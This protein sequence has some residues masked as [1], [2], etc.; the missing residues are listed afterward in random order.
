MTDVNNGRAGQLAIARVH[1]G[2]CGVQD[3]ERLTVAFSPN[4][5]RDRP[6]RAREAVLDGVPHRILS[7][8]RSKLSAGF[9]VAELEPLS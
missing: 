4:I 7:M 5:G 6:E 9:Y 2:S 8:A 1:E 3:F